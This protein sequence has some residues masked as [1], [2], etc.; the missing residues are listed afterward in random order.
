MKGCGEEQIQPSGVKQGECPVEPCT[1]ELEGEQGHW[2]TAALPSL[3]LSSQPPFIPQFLLKQPCD[4]CT[5]LAKALPASERSMPGAHPGWHE[6]SSGLWVTACS[7][8]LCCLI[9]PE[10]PSWLMGPCLPCPVLQQ[11]RKSWEDVAHPHLWPKGND[12]DMEIIHFLRGDTDNCPSA[13]KLPGSS[14]GGKNQD[15]MWATDN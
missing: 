10:Q 2:N 14:C 12:F 13:S 9:V 1:G 8:Q 15:L 7:W 4:C 5:H 6:D 3:S 11:G